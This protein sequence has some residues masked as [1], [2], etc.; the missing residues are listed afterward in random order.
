MV[1]AN[2]F[3]FGQSILGI[4]HPPVFSLTET[5]RNGGGSHRQI[6]TPEYSVSE[7]ISQ[8]SVEC[9]YRL[10]HLG[11]LFGSQLGIDGNR[12]SLFGCTLRLR[13]AS[14]PVT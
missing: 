6:C 9:G 4:M 7:A 2:Y 12:D 1:K 13:E 11:L 8:L 5:C 10:N 14:F 3:P